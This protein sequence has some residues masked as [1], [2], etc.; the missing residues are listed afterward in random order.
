[1][2]PSRSRSRRSPCSSLQVLVPHQ[3]ESQSFEEIHIDG[4]LATPK[5]LFDLSVACQS[6]NGSRN[7]RPPV[8]LC[9]NSNNLEAR[10]GQDTVLHLLERVRGGGAS[11]RGRSA[12][13]V[14][15]R[16]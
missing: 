2:K 11:R 7:P 16:Y 8:W 14:A 9:A 3:A 4:C 13:P 5:A 6:S 12:A 15:V 1:M 10:F